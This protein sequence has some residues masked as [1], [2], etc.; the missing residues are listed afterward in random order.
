MPM[1]GGD[2]RALKE[3]EDEVH[4]L[5][6]PAGDL[7]RDAKGLG[8]RRRTT[9]GGRPPFDDPR[10]RAL[11]RAV[12]QAHA[13]DDLVGDARPDGGHR[14]AGGDLARRRP[15]GHEHVPGR[16]L[17]GADGAGRGRLER[18][19]AAVRADRGPR[20]P[21]GVHRAGD[22]GRGH[23]ARAGRHPRHHRR[24]AGDRP[25]LQ[26]AARPRRRRDRRGADLSRR[27]AGVRLLRGGRRADRARRPGH[28]RRPDGGGARPPRRRGARAEVHLHRPVVPEPRRGHAVAG[29]PAAAGRRRQAPRAARARGQPVRAA[30]LR[31][32]SA[33]DAVL[34]RR[35]R[36]RHLPGHVL[37]D[38][39]ARAAPRLD[40]GAA[41]GA[42]EDEPRQG[43]RRPLPVVAVPALRAS[44]TSPS[45]TGA[46]TSAR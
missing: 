39:L 30:A 31:G 6:F 11:R 13:I 16:G 2:A 33:A 21:E 18:R 1:A 4:G 22:G 34:A 14:A 37:E 20:R 26:D 5:A 44:P 32:R 7:R 24:P 8:R 40:R 38:P 28:A 29:A 10:P 45:A 42:G 25:R 23:G 15:A 36:V 3:I 17:R 43:Q 46:A 27:G 9:Q 19:R 12:R 41:A 35:R